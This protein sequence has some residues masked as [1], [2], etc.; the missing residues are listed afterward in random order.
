MSYTQICEL[1]KRIFREW[2]GKIVEEKGAIS[3]ISKNALGDKK[4]ECKVTIGLLN[5]EKYPYHVD[6]IEN[7]YSIIGGCGCPCENLE[8]VEKDANDMLERYKF[9]K[10]E[11]ISL[12]D[13]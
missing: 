9:S 5:S 11:S 6:G 10:K 13:F 2:E 3:L 1:G 7:T 12:F 8:E 4:V